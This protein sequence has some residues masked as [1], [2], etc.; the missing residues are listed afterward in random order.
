M[1]APVLHDAYIALGSNMGD[2]AGF[3]AA[4]LRRMRDAGIAVVSVS[5]IYETD[6]VGYTEQAAFLNQVCRVR[7]AFPPEALLETL[8]GIET[9]L[10]RVRTIHWGPRTLDLDLLLYDDVRMQT[11]AL[12]LPHPRLFERAFVLVPLRDVWPS[13]QIAGRPFP[14]WI[15]ACADKDGVRPFTPTSKK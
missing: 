3:L 8:L 1:N 6:P 2:R 14:E 7:T 10:G 5:G 12:T 4:A 15:A 13:E 11:E 9:A